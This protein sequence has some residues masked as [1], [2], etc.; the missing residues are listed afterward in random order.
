MICFNCYNEE[1][2]EY[3]VEDKKYT[4]GEEV[5]TV[6]VINT[7]CPECNSN[8]FNNILDKENLQKA[9]IKLKEKTKSPTRTF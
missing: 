1:N 8:V 7:Y 9:Y 4:I 6:E 5:V 3:K 2:F